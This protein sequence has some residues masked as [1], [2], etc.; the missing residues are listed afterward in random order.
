MR[1]YSC[2]GYDACLTKAA[3]DDA[4]DLPCESCLQ[5]DTANKEPLYEFDAMVALIRA[6]FTMRW[7]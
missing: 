6:I 2:S 4:C 3:R 7:A 5:K 1:N